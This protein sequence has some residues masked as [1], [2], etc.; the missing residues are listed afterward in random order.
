VRLQTLHLA[1]FR[2]YDSLTL[3]LQGA[4]LHV[5]VGQNGSG[6]T[7]LLDAICVLSQDQSCLG[8][9]EQDLVRQGTMHYQVNAAVL[10]DA[11][12]AESLEVI[13]QLSPRRSKVCFR[14]DVR[15][16][17]AQFVGRLPTVLFLPEDLSLFTGAPS[18]RRRFL[19]QLLTQVSPDYFQ[20]GSD[21]Q[22]LLKQRNALLKRIASR[23]ASEAELDP[24][25]AEVAEKGSALTVARLELIE[26]FSLALGD[27]LRALGESWKDVRLQYERTGREREVAALAIEMQTLLRHFRQRDILLQAT[28]VGPHRDDWSILV[29]GMS[30][31]AYASRGQQR[32]AVLS[33]L[34]LEASFL[35]VRRGEKPVILLDDIFSELDDAH[36]MRVMQAFPGHQVL[37]TSVHVPPVVGE[38]ALWAVESGTVR[39]R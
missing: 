12:E 25:D 38:A 10:S 13:S 15:I 34:F 20:T 1:Q 7:N 37:L 6:K 3:D 5:F 14:N 16:P 21:F 18:E 28:T 36:Q 26:T 22:K 23:E 19:D 2:S 31:P 27:E 35:E 24:W 4:D 17:V 32:A 33:L 11:T 9:A 8:H 29:D 30:L 39:K